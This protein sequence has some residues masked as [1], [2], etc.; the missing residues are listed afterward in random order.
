MH[1]KMSRWGV[2]PVFALLSLGYGAIILGISRYYHPAFRIPYVPQWLLSGLGVLLLSI[3]IPFFGLSV[4]TV[5]K[6]YNSDKLVTHGTYGCCRHPLYSAWVVFIVP[7]MV[8]MVNS[9]IGLTVPLVMY[10]I[11]KNLVIKEEVYLQRVFGAEY[12]KY[13]QETPCILPLGCVK[14][15]KN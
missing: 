3:G 4:I 2:G 8:L 5:M 7:A 9:W 15:L 6:A 10:A 13:A 14:R 1:D 11:L 12:V